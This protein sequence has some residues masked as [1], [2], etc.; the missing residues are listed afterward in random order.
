MPNKILYG[1][2]IENPTVK[3]E[4]TGAGDGMWSVTALYGFEDDGEFALLFAGTTV[5]VPSG[6]EGLPDMGD[7]V[8]ESSVP[9]KAWLDTLPET[10]PEEDPDLW[11][12][13]RVEDE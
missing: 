10:E 3:M 1:V 8:K 6:P 7:A 12:K 11:R 4:V 5:F 13:S 2:E 9:I